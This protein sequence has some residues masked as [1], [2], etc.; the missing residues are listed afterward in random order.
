MYNE[1]KEN[2]ARSINIDTNWKI[3]IKTSPFQLEFIH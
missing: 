2:K 3:I 1:I